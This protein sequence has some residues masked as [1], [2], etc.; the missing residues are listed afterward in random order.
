MR[1]CLRG[2]GCDVFVCACILVCAEISPRTEVQNDAA[3]FVRECC[4]SALLL[5]HRVEMRALCCM[6]KAQW[7]GLCKQCLHLAWLHFTCLCCSGLV[8]LL[9]VS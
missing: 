4:R 5:C 9:F 3:G 1:W 7:W 6:D 8:P 2:C